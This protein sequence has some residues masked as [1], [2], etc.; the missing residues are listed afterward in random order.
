MS[1]PDSPQ[2][3]NGARADVRDPGEWA[4]ATHWSV[5][6]EARNSFSPAAMQALDQL[7]R[8]YWYPIYA[9]IRRRGYK[10]EEAEDLTQNF[11]LHLLE[12]DALKAVD[13][14]KGRFRAFLLVALKN[15][16]INQWNRSAEAGRREAACFVG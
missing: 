14:A 5:V 15:F 12:Q 4:P 11:F 1:E 16:L 6:L 7:C 9:Y 10:P 8:T 2:T 3:T 13:Q